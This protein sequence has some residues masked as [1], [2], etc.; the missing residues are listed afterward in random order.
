L[1]FRITQSE[2]PTTL[3]ISF[4]SVATHFWRGLDSGIRHLLLHSPLEHG[5]KHGENEHRNTRKKENKTKPRFRRR[6]GER[7]CHKLV[8]YV[9]FGV[10]VSASAP[11]RVFFFTCPS[12]PGFIVCL[13][14]CLARTFE[15][16]G[17]DTSECGFEPRMVFCFGMLRHYDRNEQK[18]P[19]HLPRYLRRWTNRNMIS[20]VALVQSE[21][22]AFLSPL[23]VKVSFSVII[24]DPTLRQTGV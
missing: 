1:S 10:L 11:L 18:L 3:L 22:Q 13:L 9:S 5:K 15:R 19:Y 23:C 2:L 16:N 17:T 6:G 24:V 8:V 21:S 20:C 14:C 12:V 7:A 4:I